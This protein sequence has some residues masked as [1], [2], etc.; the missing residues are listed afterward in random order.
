MRRHI[1][2]PTHI[3]VHGC[4]LCIFGWTADTCVSVVTYVR[5]L[6]PTYLPCSVAVV[7][8]TM[9][10]YGDRRQGF[11]EHL[12]GHTVIKNNWRCKLTVGMRR[13]PSSVAVALGEVVTESLGNQ[14]GQH[15]AFERREFL[16]CCLF[17]SLVQSVRI[18]VFY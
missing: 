12:D 6:A 5:W 14:P 18:V 3:H 16:D 7:A 10:A 2:P 1:D 13:Q 8:T 4:T 11:G 9:L 15:L 17:V